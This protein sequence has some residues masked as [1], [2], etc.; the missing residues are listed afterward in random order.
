M[1][2][3]KII[4][5]GAN[6][7]GKTSIVK[8]LE[9][10][11]VHSVVITLHGYYHPSF[12]KIIKDSSQAK[13]YHSDRLKSLLPAFSKVKAEELILNRFHTTASVYLK[14]FYKI[15]GIFGLSRF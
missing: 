11:F 7:S 15:E 5:E 12:L 9:K 13:E 10:I 1:G 6:L 3:S 2:V 4:I 8:E 14:L